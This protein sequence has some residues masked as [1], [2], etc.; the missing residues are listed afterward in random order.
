MRVTSLLVCLALVAA[1]CG[2][3]E[4]D[5]TTTTTTAVVTTTATT[6][7]TT[8]TRRTTTTT[9][10]GDI[11]PLTGL[12]VDDPE[13]LEHRAI[14]VKVDNHPNARPQTGLPDA[15][16]V[17]ELPVEG[18]SRLVGVFQTVDPAV[19]GPV[20]SIRPTDWQVANMFDAPIVV[21][22]GQSWVIT[23][24]RDNGAYIIGEI[25]SPVTFR[26]SSRRAPHNLY[27]DVAAARVRAD[28]VE[29][30][31]DP[32]QTIWEFGP[33]PR[34]ADEATEL[35]LEFS[36]SLVAGWEFTDGVYRRTTNGAVHEWIGADGEASQIEV[37]VL[38]VLS[39]ET[40]L[41]QPPPG[42]GVARAV[43]SVGS[44][45]AWVFADGRVVAGRWERESSR[46]PFTLTDADGDTMVV[47][48]GHAWVSYFPND[49][50]P[51]WS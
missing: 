5:D 29:V 1:A 10:P 11:S 3:D 32:P 49:E 14:V 44:G 8:T 15:D 27:V 42:G 2:G 12:P 23:K 24:N 37:D 47:P 48:P 18:I 51:E 13:V 34:D 20:R 26:S 45:D 46:D 33:M 22:G 38:V 50:T 35:R 41:A 9:T 19:A 43:E 17:L 28:E 6:R 4:A 7:P 40:Y 16:M 21:S 25:G 36:G 30:A 31:D 39:M